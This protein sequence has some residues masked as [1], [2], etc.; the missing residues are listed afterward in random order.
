ML[1]INFV[2]SFLLIS[3]KSSTILDSESVIDLMLSVNLF[4]GFLSLLISDKL[5]TRFDSETCMNR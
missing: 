5:S 4:S 2:C 1:S 3:D